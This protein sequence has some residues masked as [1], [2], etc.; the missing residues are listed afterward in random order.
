MSVTISPSNPI[1]YSDI[2]YNYGFNGLELDPIVYNTQAIVVK[3]INT[4][5]TPKGSRH[6]N[7]LFGNDEQL[8][9]KNIN[10]ATAYTYLNKIVYTLSTWV[11]MVTINR[12]ESYIS[13]SNETSSIYIYLS[14]LISGIQSPQTLNLRY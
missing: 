4:L 6:F 8:L 13:G 5:F 14:Y 1:V 10:S 3:I 2:N 12:S 11:P 9:F 7:P